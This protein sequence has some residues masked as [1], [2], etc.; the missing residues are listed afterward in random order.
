M[1]D[2]ADEH[3]SELLKQVHPADWTNP[4]PTGPYN[5][6]AI[7]GGTAG[8]IAALGAAGLGARVALVEKHLLGG[9]CLNFGCVPSKALIRCGRAA[10]ETSTADRFGCDV[11]SEAKIDFSAV[12]K[13]MRQ[14]RARISHHDSAERFARLGVDVYLG[15]ASFAGRDT[16]TVGGQQIRFR[17]AVIATGSRP[18]V[19]DVEG[20]AE[21]GYLTNETV[22]SL[23]E[24]PRRLVVLG[25]GPIG[26]ELAQCFRR[27]GS[28]VHLVGRS[29]Q[30]LKKEDPAAAAIV[31]Q[32]FGAEGIHLCLGWR[33]IRAELAGE[34]KT[35]LIAR[36]EEKRKLIADEFV[37]ATG[38]QPNVEG[39]GLDAAGVEFT[40][41]G[42]KVNDRLQTTNSRI[43]AAGDVCSQ[44]QFTHAAD[45]MARL[46]V[47]NALF[48]GRKR[49]SRLVIPRVTY[50]D[51]E[52]AHVGL[53]PAEAAAQ[54][55][56]IDSYRADLSEVD[57][58]VIDGEESG[59]AVIH[60]KRGKSTVVGA[61]IVASHAGEMLGEVTL[62]QTER[63][64]LGTLAATIHAYPTQAEVLK[65]I[66]DN[67]NR[68]RLT[69][70][71]AKL[72]KFWLKWMR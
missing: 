60:T 17:R 72:L 10:Y 7:G 16:L 32:Q 24:L 40:E 35:L 53:T 4:K 20:L 3:D 34:A 36:G 67:Y 49:F 62:L 55:V 2:P 18:A 47:Q 65:R 33:A 22:F 9:D 45:A 66:A 68:T 25:S 23:K 15:R 39:L 69:P 28:D 19:P 43:Y 14:L 31:R 41:H 21:I 46:V 64:S 63:L 1:L 13:R 26:C 42:V 37:V 38:R 12:M 51:P 29:L 61:T 54:G 30:I 57:R 56:E 59:F 44:Q 6:V 11:S 71:V 70:R 5:L 27:L 8:I 52:L 50:T 58:A 48:F